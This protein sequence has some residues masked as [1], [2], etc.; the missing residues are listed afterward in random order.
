MPDDELS[1]HRLVEA[2]KFG[3]GRRF[4]LGD[5]EAVEI[6]KS[7]EKALRELAN[8]TVSQSVAISNITESAHSDPGYY[9]SP[10]SSTADHG[11]GHVCIVAANGAALCLVSS[12]NTPFGSHLLSVQG[13]GHLVQQRDERLLDA[14]RRERARHP[15]EQQQ[16]RDPARDAARLLALPHRGG[17]RKRRRPARRHCHGRTAHHIGP[18]A[19]RAVQSPQAGPQALPVQLDRHGGGHSEEGPGRVRGYR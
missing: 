13:D 17:G 16:Q 18:D 9:G 5:S 2:L 10:Q 4:M 6:K 12:I 3:F 1:I 15:G 11:S 7:F 8:P 14:P 19:G